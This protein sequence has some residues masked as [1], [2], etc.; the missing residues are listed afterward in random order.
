VVASL[1]LILSAVFNIGTHPAL[2]GRCGMVQC[3]ALTWFLSFA[4]TALWRCPGFRKSVGIYGFLTAATVLVYGVFFNAPLG[5]WIAFSMFICYVI[6]LSGSAA[7]SP[8]ETSGA[9]TASQARSQ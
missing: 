4:T 5:E 1:A 8:A 9:S 2:H 7:G 6:L 3:I